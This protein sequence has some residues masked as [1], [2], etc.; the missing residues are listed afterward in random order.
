MT[1]NVNNLGRHTMHLANIAITSLKLGV[2]LIVI[3][4][5][6]FF[7]MV[8][9]TNAY[10]DTFRNV[11]ITTSARPT[12]TTNGIEHKVTDTVREFSKVDV[13]DKGSDT[14]SDES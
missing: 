12:Y 14:S 3:N 2:A 6:T 4:L 8:F 1:V 7:L 9:K 5:I 10:C 13:K 11:D